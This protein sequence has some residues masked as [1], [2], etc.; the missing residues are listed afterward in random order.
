MTAA[1]CFDSFNQPSDI[2]ARLGDHDLKQ[3]TESIYSVDMNI[4]QIVRHPQYNPQ[5]AANDIAI[6][7]TETDIIYTRGVGPAC[8]PIL[9]DTNFFNNKILTAV[10]WGSQTFAG[11]LSPVLREVQLN[12]IS[13]SNCALRGYPNL[14][15]SQLCTFTNGKD[16][17]Q[18]SILT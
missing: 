13:N 4:I 18:V 14:V 10:G 2:V 6:V 5:T 9:Y 15:S 16:T 12:V 7:T 11:P 8:L 17:C 3:S 1:H